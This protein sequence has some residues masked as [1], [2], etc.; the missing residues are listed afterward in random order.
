MEKTTPFHLHTSLP[1]IPVIH[2]RKR[3]NTSFHVLG[4][5]DVSMEN[6]LPSLRFPPHSCD[7]SDTMKLQSLNSAKQIHAQIIKSASGWNSDS[8]VSKLI[9]VYA[10]MGDFRS[11]AMVFFMGFE[12][13]SLSWSSL[14]EEFE[15]NGGRWR[16]LLAIL[17]ELHRE[18]M[19]FDCRILTAVLRICTSLMDSRLGEEIHAC[20]IK[21]GF[22]SDIHLK[23]ALMEFYLNCCGF[24]CIAKMF[25]EMEVR[26]PLLWKE[27]I[28]LNSRN[29]LWLESLELFRQMQF[30]FVEADGFTIAKVLQACGRV[31]ALK[32]GMQIHGYVIR[33][34]CIS[35][36]LICNSL[37][38]MYSKNSKLVLARA[39]FDSMGSHSSVSWN[40]M[41]S[42][43]ALNGFI[44]EAWKLLDEMA[45]S[46]TKPDIVT[47]SSLVSGHSLYGLHDE[48]LKVLWRMQ[49]A[50]FKPNS[51]SITSVLQAVS[52]SG[53]LRLGKEI[54]GYAIRNGIVNDMYVGTSLVDMYVKKGR[55]TDARS[56]VYNLKFRN[57]FAWNSLISGYAYNGFF[58]KALELL[59]EMEKDGIKPDL[60]TWNSLISGYAMKGL[61]K[62][63]LVLIRQL[64]ML[65]LNPNVVSWTALISGCSQTG[66]YVESLDFFVQMQQAG[67]K[68][69]SATIA[70]SLRACA[71]LAMLLKGAELHCSAIRNG[72]DRDIFVATALID[73]YCKSG[74][75]HNASRVFG[76]IQNKNLASWNAMIMG[77]AIHGLGEEVILLFNEMCKMGIRPDGI[78]FTALLSGCRHSGM[79]AEGWKYF[80]SMRTEYGINPTLEHYACMVD[81]LGR[82]GYV[83]EAWDFL[84]TMPL[85]PDAAMWGALL[86]ACRIHRNL[87]LAEIAAENLFKLEPDNSGN[88]LLLMNL[89][90]AEN[91]WEDV[92]NLRDVMNIVG[93]KNRPGWS[94]IRIDHMVHLFSVDG[95]PHPDVGEI[96]F[97][98]YQLVLKIQKMGYEPDTSCV[99]QNVDEEEKKL[100]LLS[101]TEKL[102]ITYGLIKTG[103]GTPIRV[104]KNTRVCNDCHSMAKYISQISCREIFL[105]DGVRFHHFAGGKCSCNDYW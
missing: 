87:E 105:R 93:V 26:N 36:L 65:G 94:W 98:L 40:S 75:L 63:A 56:V 7:F 88:Y 37:I 66:N 44:D 16:E 4:V 19:I 10:E 27:A 79:L 60:I 29:G 68:P 76:K 11:A 74:S 80:D 97:E 61:S 77:F 84:R 28:M 101:H 3:S 18:E 25:D 38:S 90:A 41:I 57:V 72:F 64:R 58:D 20:G 52:E 91:R 8:F 24:E 81:L 13:N 62:Q 23:C 85:E 51:S 14:M 21:S 30:S 32:Q 12:R 104:I 42:G 34:G 22:D 35:D 102:A 1:R 43:Y 70:S 96:Y 95:K 6:L 46:E 59:K 9:C 83:D 39:V 82:G 100:L 69:N 89:Y 49:T 92:E 78:T 55:L 2:K 67:I 50:G 86:G 54:H 47:W 5:A 45:L 103:E 48:I 73:M 53:L 17:H 33:S 71:G 31:G 15:K 99:V